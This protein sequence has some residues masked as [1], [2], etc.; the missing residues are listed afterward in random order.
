MNAEKTYHWGS[1]LKEWAQAA[2]WIAGAALC[3]TAAYR[4]I[5]A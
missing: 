2:F 3:V 1:A 4:F 5:F